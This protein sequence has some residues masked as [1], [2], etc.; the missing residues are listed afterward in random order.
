M[1]TSMLEARQAEPQQQS[2][3]G[4]QQR[5]PPYMSTK[6]SLG[7][8]PTVKVDIPITAVFLF[9]FILGAAS[10]MYILQVNQKRKH[11]FLISGMLFG[12]CMSRI[13]TMIL[14]IAWTTRVTNIRL[15]IAANI[16]VYAGV[17]L[18]FV[19]NV[20]FAQRIVR[21][22]HPNTGWHP[23]FHWAF[24]GIYS[25]IVVTLVML[26][27]SVIQSFYTLNANTKRIDRDILL[28]GQTFYAVVSF[29]PFPL[30]LG[31][32]ILPRTT[33]RE[34]F[35]HGRFTS[36]VLY[37]MFASFLLCLGAAFRAGTNYAGGERPINHPAGYQSKACFYIFNFAVEIV[38]V[39][40]Y[41]I[42]RV[43]KRFYVPDHSKKPGDYSRGPDFYTRRAQGLNA[44]PSGEAQL[45]DRIN[46]EEEV[47]DDMNPDDLAKRDE[48]R[49]IAAG[50]GSDKDIPLETLPTSA[51]APASS[52][53]PAP[54]AGH[55]ESKSNDAVP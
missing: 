44:K 50:I 35:G 51:P 55:A 9:L 10:H 47:F 46:Q 11:K 53:A 36:K 42:I 28:Y 39:L 37:L 52:E 21:S 2:A 1:S 41:V 49:G 45:S 40:L 15:A 29:L 8:F 30:V 13:V 7:G 26:I 16:F 5:G 22:C 6:A 23:L 33:R 32:L 14:R 18:L 24:V 27:I 20:I 3:M 4:A 43:D 31:G 34:K 25:L 19:A 38:V 54:A 17:V 12:F 48:E